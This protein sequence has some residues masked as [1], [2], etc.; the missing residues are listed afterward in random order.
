MLCLSDITFFEFNLFKNEFLKRT[1][2]NSSQ[3]AIRSNNKEKIE[4]LPG[5]YSIGQHVQGFESEILSLCY[6]FAIHDAFNFLLEEDF[7]G[8]SCFSFSSLCIIRE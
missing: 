3:C 2:I 4:N 5:F 8:G 6:P 7:K 1:L